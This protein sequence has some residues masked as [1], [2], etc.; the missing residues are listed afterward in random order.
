MN[1]SRFDVVSLIK[2]SLKLVPDEQAGNC[3]RY[4]REELKNK[5]LN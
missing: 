4:G 1:E 5:E 2:Q 3:A